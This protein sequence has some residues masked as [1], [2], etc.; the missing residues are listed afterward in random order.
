MAGNFALNLGTPADAAAFLDP[1]QNGSDQYI[2]TYEPTALIDK[3]E[4]STRFEEEDF[5][6]RSAERIA[7][8]DKIQ[9]EIGRARAALAVIPQYAKQ[10][11]RYAAF[12]IEGINTVDFTANPTF[13]LG[14][15]RGTGQDFYLPKS[16]KRALVI[17]A[18]FDAFQEGLLIW[19]YSH[20]YIV[21][22]LENG[23]FMSVAPTF[24]GGNLPN[25]FQL[26]IPNV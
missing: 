12:A 20:P 8:S 15:N 23:N 25:P 16:Y 13:L 2:S 18:Y 4:A 21:P 3:L 5:I 7:T 6:L 19:N 24:R 1:G 26:Q 9:Q 22:I 11:A 14:A 10:R 17:K